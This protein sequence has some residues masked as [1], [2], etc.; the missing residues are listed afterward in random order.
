MKALLLNPGL[1]LCGAGF[2]PP[3]VRTSKLLVN[4]GNATRRAIEDQ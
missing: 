2:L 1:L 3:Y 4:H